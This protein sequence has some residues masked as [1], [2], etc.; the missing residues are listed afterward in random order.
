M[1]CLLSYVK[2]VEIIFYKKEAIG[3]KTVL[4]DKTMIL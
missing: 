3:Y 4:I 2:L 1:T